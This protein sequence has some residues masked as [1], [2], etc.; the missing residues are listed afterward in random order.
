MPT[1]DWSKSHTPYGDAFRADVL[2]AV[3]NRGSKTIKQVTDSWGVYG[4]RTIYNWSRGSIDKRV[5]EVRRIIQELR[6]GVTEEPPV[7]ELA[8]DDVDDS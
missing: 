5:P 1:K 8:E 2:E 4:S 3:L 6:A 7:S